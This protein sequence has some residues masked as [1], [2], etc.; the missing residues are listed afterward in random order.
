[1]ADTTTLGDPTTTAVGSESGT[2]LLNDVAFFRS[3]RIGLLYSF[4]TPSA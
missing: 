2:V 3:I 4:S 1:M